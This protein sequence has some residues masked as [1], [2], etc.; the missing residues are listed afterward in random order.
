MCH[1]ALSSSGRARHALW[2]VCEREE[3]RSNLNLH[4]ACSV[5]RGGIMACVGCD[6][7]DILVNVIYNFCLNLREHLRAALFIVKR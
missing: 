6:A 7:V 2:C 3:I 4:G 1:L 5:W